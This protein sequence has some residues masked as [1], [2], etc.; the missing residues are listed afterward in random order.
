MPAAEALLAPPRYGATQAGQGALDPAQHDRWY[1]QLNLE[2]PARATAQFGSRLVQEQQ[3][4]L[5]ASAWEQAA[6]L[7]SVNT[8]L[9]HA[10]FGMAMGTSLHQ[11]HLSRMSPD[12]GLQVLAPAWAQLMLTTEA[13]R[14]DTGLVAM[15][16]AS[17]V[18]AA[19]FGTTMRRLA[20]PRG[21]IARRVAA[22]RR[23]AGLPPTPLR[24]R[25]RRPRRP[26][27]A[28]RC[29]ACSPTSCAVGP[30]C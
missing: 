2:A 4:A 19:A 3:E 21:A 28:A 20:R 26:P 22:C 7:R 18:P 14:P 9:R 30:A 24:R 12:A 23:G 16:R 15:L 6:E 1:E 5:V 11:R 10:Q 13:N 29:A 27:R 8:V 25:R 17:Q